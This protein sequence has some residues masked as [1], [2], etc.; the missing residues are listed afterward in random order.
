MKLDT[1]LEL[2]MIATILPVLNVILSLL[3]LAVV[4]A[5][6]ARHRLVVVI[7]SLSW[8]H[9]A[10]LLRLSTSSHLERSSRYAVKCWC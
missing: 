3:V 10:L 6:L 7:T 5:I 8:P 2:F 4:I 1:T 9:R